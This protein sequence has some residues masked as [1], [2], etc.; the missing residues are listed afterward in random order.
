[1]CFWPPDNPEFRCLL[2]GI[3]RVA[4]VGETDDLSRPMT[5]PAEGTTKVGCG[6]CIDA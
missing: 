5:V 6:V 2:D 1:M 4:T 3:R